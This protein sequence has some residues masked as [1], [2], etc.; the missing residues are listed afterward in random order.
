[1]SIFLKSFFSILIISIFCNLFIF[2]SVLAKTDYQ[3]G[4]FASQSGYSTTGATASL[5]TAVQLVINVVLSLVGI[6]FL[7]L[8]VYAGVR[9][10]TAQGNSEAVTK[11]QETLQAAIIG[12]VVVSMSYAISTL[13]FDTL[14]S[15]IPQDGTLVGGKVSCYKDTDCT[16][17]DKCNPMGYCYTETCS[18]PVAKCGAYCSK[19][20]EENQ[21][22][23]DDGDCNFSNNLVCFMSACT[24]VAPKP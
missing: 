24:K 11:A 4:A 1:M 18:D 23:N 8:A 10:M 17:G 13:I 7:V 2:T 3:L 14:A 12:M 5:P 16:A 15:K 6:F 22:C 21:K 9:W 20:C 19:P